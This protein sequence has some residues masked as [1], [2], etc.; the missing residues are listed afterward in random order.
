M[1]G[2]IAHW[3]KY[4]DQTGND[5]L[6]PTIVYAGDVLKIDLRNMYG[7]YCVLAMGVCF[8]LVS[9]TVEILFGKIVVPNLPE[10]FRRKK[11]NIRN[12]YDSALIGYGYSNARP[13]TPSK[14]Q[15]L[16]G[17]RKQGT[18]ANVVLAQ[19]NR[20]SETNN[21]NNNSGSGSVH[22]SQFNTVYDNLQ[23]TKYNTK[24][25][26]NLFNYDQK[27]SYRKLN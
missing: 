23:T 21:N 2:Y 6:K 7:S 8:S 15:L 13:D 26:Y 19:K 12:Y 18:L 20:I 27:S 9:V 5:C 24:S 3:H 25:N 14:Q 16:E 22:S 17:G 1:T 4:F 11:D 10:S